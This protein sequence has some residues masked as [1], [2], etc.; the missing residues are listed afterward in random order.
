MASQY[1]IKDILRRT[2]NYLYRF[3]SNYSL[4][5][6]L[7]WIA[8]IPGG[9]KYLAVKFTA[10][11]DYDA[12]TIYLWLKRRGTPP[13]DLTVELC[14]DSPG[15]PSTVLQT[16]TIT[17]TNISDTVSQLY[18]ITITAESLTSGTL[19]WIK[20]YSSDA[21]SDN[22]WAVGT[23]NAAG[24]SKESADGTT[25]SDSAIDVYYRITAAD[26]DY[27]TRFFTYKRQ[28]YM[29][30]NTTGAA[31]KLYINGDRGAADANTGALTTLVDA[32]KAWTVNEWAGCVAMLIGGPGSNEI[33][34]WRTI[35][36]KRQPINP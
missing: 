12:T 23:N 32:T 26:G 11:A 25:W 31:P 4:P 2:G 36:S 16:A 1:R 5:G 24:T 13:E 20:A 21:D 33:K 18:K 19:Y 29:V 14:S 30:H 9:Q 3:R 27:Q 22:Y 8:I 7:K 15:N 35:V 6:S 17:T 34:P 28:L 10:S